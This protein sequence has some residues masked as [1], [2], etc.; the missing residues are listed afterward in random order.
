MQYN[1]KLYFNWPLSIVY[2]QSH[3]DTINKMTEQKTTSCLESQLAEGKPVGYLQVQGE[4]GTTRIKF[5]K[6]SERILNPWSPGPSCS[7]AG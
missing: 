5:D 6:W 3:W 4:P 7:N 2:F 1:I